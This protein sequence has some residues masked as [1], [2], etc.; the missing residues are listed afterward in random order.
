MHLYIFMIVERD[1]SQYDSFTQVFKWTTTNMISKI[2][3]EHSPFYV[4]LKMI[5]TIYRTYGKAQLNFLHLP[6]ILF[7]SIL[8]WEVS[9]MKVLIMS[10]KITLIQEEKI[11]LLLKL[12]NSVLI[13]WT[14]ICFFNAESFYKD[15]ISLLMNW[16]KW[17]QFPRWV[18]LTKSHTIV[19]LFHVIENKYF[20][21]SPVYVLFVCLFFKAAIKIAG[22][23]HAKDYAVVCNLPSEHHWKISGREWKP[24]IIH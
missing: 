3:L 17:H 7:C 2:F 1:L 10:L 4:F 8:A 9:D 5:Y 19:I 13:R 12:S 21:R 15:L 23:Q 11:M 18:L 16:K 20:V 6:L 14:W 24:G 22:K